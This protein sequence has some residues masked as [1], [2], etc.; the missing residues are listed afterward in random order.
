MAD[1]K[2]SP[3]SSGIDIKGKKEQYKSTKAQVEELK[4]NIAYTMLKYLF[5][6]TGVLIAAAMGVNCITSVFKVPYNFDIKI[7]LEFASPIITFVLGYIFG[8][9]AN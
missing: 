3:V 5:I 4:I 2:E 1:N 8:R 9:P 6:G 7:L